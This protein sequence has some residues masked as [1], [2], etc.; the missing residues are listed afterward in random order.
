MG[1]ANI[2][3]VDKPVGT[4]FSYAKSLEVYNISGTLVAAELYEFLQKWLKVHPKFLTN[5]LHVM[6]DSW[7]QLS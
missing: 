1:V 5:S 3:F 2:I 6:G 7:V 4:E